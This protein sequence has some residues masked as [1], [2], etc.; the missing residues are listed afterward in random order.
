MDIGPG[1]GKYGFLI[2]EYFHKDVDGDWTPVER[3][4]CIDIFPDYISQMHHLIYDNVYVGN[5]TEFDFEKYDLFLLI[6]IIEHIPKEEGFKLLDNLT[7]KG[8]V[9]VS[10][11]VD[12]GDQGEMYGNK[13]EAHISQWT[14]EDFERYTVLENVSNELSYIYVIT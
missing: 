8:F 11:P 6:D 5:A 7:K 9:F 14:P 3:L 10:T 4:D 1:R 12:I 2:R 13:H